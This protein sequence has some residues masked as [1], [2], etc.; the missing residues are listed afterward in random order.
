MN[1][2]CIDLDE[3]VLY[4]R[5]NLSVEVDGTPIVKDYL[6]TING[7][8]VVPLPD[9]LLKELRMWHD[10]VG[11]NKGICSTDAIVS[12]PEGFLFR[13]VKDQTVHVASTNSISRVSRA[14]KRCCAEIDPEF[15]ESFTLH[16]LRHTYV[17]RLFE[18]GVNV[19]A[20][21]FIVGHADVNTTLGIYA[22]FDRKSRQGDVF[23]EVK[24]AI[25]PEGRSEMKT[26]KLRVV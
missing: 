19:K 6:K 24:K 25:T 13:H 14:I 26:P 12:S 11:P 3:E 18:A 16:I 20:I 22:H 2:D 9:I 8:R 23:G 7:V 17:T 10:N 5:R 4:V 21:Q 1:W 15:A